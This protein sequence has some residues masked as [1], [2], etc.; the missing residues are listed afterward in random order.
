MD[1]NLFESCGYCF[2]TNV[3]MI[4]S[5]CGLCG[6]SVCH[7]CGGPNIYRGT[8]IGFICN[9]CMPEDFGRTENMPDISLYYRIYAGAGRDSITCP[10]CYVL[11]WDKGTC[12]EHYCERASFARDPFHYHAY[13]YKH[14]Q[15][16]AE[17]IRQKMEEII[18]QK[19]V[20]RLING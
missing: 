8:T 18:S 5:Q 3:S 16:N 15:F 1:E 7:I 13:I 2:Q 11:V 10:A 20:S 6:K 14:P 17:F 12:W 9:K 4:D 19:M